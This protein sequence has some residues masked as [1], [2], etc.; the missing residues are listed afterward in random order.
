LPLPGTDD[1]DG[2]CRRLGDPDGTR[3]FAD[4]FAD[5]PPAGVLLRRC[6]DAAAGGR[7]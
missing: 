7:L 6:C 4:L 2:S 5:V 1:G 3:D